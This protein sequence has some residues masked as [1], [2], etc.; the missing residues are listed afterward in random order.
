M[1]NS[2]VLIRVSIVVMKYHDQS[3]IGLKDLI[4]LSFLII[5][6]SLKEVRAGTQ[7]RQESKCKGYEEVLLNGLHFMACLVGLLIELGP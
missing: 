4:G 1:P 7:I 2:G 5:F 3:N 6:L